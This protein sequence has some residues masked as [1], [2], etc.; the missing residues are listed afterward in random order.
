MPQASCSDQ[1]LGLLESG[2]GGASACSSF[3]FGGGGGGFFPA[4]AFGVKD[5]AAEATVPAC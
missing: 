2:T 4:A 3:F 1:N 5:E